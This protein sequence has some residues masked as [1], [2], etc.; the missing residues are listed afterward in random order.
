MAVT[1]SE[2]LCLDF[3]SFDLA[4]RR[5]L[6]VGIIGGSGLPKI[7]VTYYCMKIYGRIKKKN[8]FNHGT[9][10]NALI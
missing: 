10:F 7:D 5:A 4:M 1:E 2:C 8:V 9:P 3:N 6:P